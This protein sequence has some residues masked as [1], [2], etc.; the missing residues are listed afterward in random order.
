MWKPPTS[1]EM[2]HRLLLRQVRDSPLADFDLE[3]QSPVSFG[4][5]AAKRQ[6]SGSVYYGALQADDSPVVTHEFAI[7][8]RH[9]LA[10]GT[11]W[12]VVEK[13]HGV[14]SVYRVRRVYALGASHL[15]LEVEEVSCGA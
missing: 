12:E 15:C 4:A 10:I 3:R 11:D 7:R 13:I 8:L 6:V 9:G 1:G 14:E 2:K 5:W